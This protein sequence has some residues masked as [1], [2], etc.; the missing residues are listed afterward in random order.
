MTEYRESKFQ[1]R[2]ARPR[3][4]HKQGSQLVINTQRLSLKNQSQKKSYNRPIDDEEMSKICNKLSGMGV[5][6]RW[7]PTG[8]FGSK[9]RPERDLAV[10]EVGQMRN[11]DSDETGRM[12]KHFTTKLQCI[13]AMAH[14]ESYSLEELRLLDFLA[15]SKMRDE[16]DEEKIKYLR[17]IGRESHRFESPKFMQKE[18]KLK[19]AWTCPGTGTV[20]F[21]PVRGSESLDDDNSGMIQD[22]TTKHQII[23]AMEQYSNKSLEELRLED[24]LLGLDRKNVLVSDDEETGD[25]PERDFSGESY[26]AGEEELKD[27]SIR[28]DDE[29]YAFVKRDGNK[30]QA[31]GRVKFIGHSPTQ[32][33]GELHVGMELEKNVGESDGSFDEIRLFKTLPYHAIIVPLRKAIPAKEFNEIMGS[34]DEMED[35]NSQQIAVIPHTWARMSA[36][37]AYKKVILNTR[38]HEYR[39][40]AH[41]FIS[42]GG[43]KKIVQIERIQNENLYHQYMAKKSEVAKKMISSGRQVERKLFHGTDEDEKIMLHGFD[44]SFAGKNATVFGRGVYFATTAQYSDN[45]ALPNQ[46]GHRRVF[47]AD[48]ITGNYC[49]GNSSLITPPMRKSGIKNDLYDSVVNNEQSPTI[50]VIFKDASAYPTHLITY[51]S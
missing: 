6:K 11:L 47:L 35:N 1:H 48:V 33:F 43:S 23:T 10:E 8:T 27:I 25:F 34:D 15:T 49:Q 38:S 3:R 28:Y 16:N 40:T 46:L 51:S 26:R 7:N 32:V 22:V 36:R 45:Y 20:D 42:S 30:I 13:T 19:C 37:D 17:K 5:E 41:K 4:V 44:R 9:F 31:K 29:V 2:G 50:F 24:Y 12:K 21:V 39:V 18:C 14:Y